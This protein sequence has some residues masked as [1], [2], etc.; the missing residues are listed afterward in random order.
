MENCF[1]SG[2]LQQKILIFK[3][4]DYTYIGTM[5]NLVLENYINL[6]MENLMEQKILILENLDCMY[7]WE[8]FMYT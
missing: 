1:P 4:I 5:E 6:Y 2:F 3:N 7:R 8:N